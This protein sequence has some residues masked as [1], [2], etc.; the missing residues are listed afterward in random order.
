MGANL[1]S[2]LCETPPGQGAPS[3]TFGEVKPLFLQPPYTMST[4]EGGGPNV[5]SPTQCEREHKRRSSFVM[6]H[7]PIS[8]YKCKQ[9]SQLLAVS[10]ALE[11]VPEEL[12]KSKQ[13]KSSAEDLANPV[14]RHGTTKRSQEHD[15]TG[16]T[17][18]NPCV[19][20]Y[21]LL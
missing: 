4:K 5:P 21:A 10:Q 1:S 2:A 16:V 14:N 8:Y 15:C 9:E 13:S 7:T 6:S 17:L 19:L 18:R 12:W 3:T 11:N 20:L